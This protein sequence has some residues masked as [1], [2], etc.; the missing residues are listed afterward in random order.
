MPAS[1]TTTTVSPPAMRPRSSWARRRS[2]PSWYETSSRARTPVWVRSFL[3]RRVSSKAQASAEPKPRAARGE[4]SA[5][6]P[7]GVPQ[8]TNFPGMRLLPACSNYAPA[9][10]LRGAGGPM[11]PSGHDRTDGVNDASRGHSNRAARRSGLDRVRRD[12][13]REGLVLVRAQLDLGVWWGTGGRASAAGEM[14]A[15]S[16]NKAV[17]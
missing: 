13:L 7:I 8:R 2:L 3:V 17:R 16:G 9:N 14:V 5:R 10:D 12:L 1:D 6:L 4:R 11:E 15:C